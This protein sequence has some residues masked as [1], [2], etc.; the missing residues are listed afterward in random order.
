ME[1]VAETGIDVQ[2][3]SVTKGGKRVADPA[4][5]PAYC[6]EWCFEDRER[7][8]FSLWFEQMVVK[9]AVVLQRVNMKDLQR[10]IE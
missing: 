5:N 9:D 3:W 7:V 1:L 10:R 8:V 6:Y 2:P 4:S